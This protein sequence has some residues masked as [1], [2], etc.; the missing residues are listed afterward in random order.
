MLIY[1]IGGGLFVSL[2]ASLL[3]L[4]ISYWISVGL[5]LVYFAGLF[6]VIKYSNKQSQILQ[7]KIHFNL[8]LVLINVNHEFLEKK[9]RLRARIGHMAQWV[10]F[11][12]LVTTRR[13]S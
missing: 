11:H 12:S 5:T 4:W 13:P 9:H 3:G 2:L 8:A 6:A 7:K 1:L 10:E